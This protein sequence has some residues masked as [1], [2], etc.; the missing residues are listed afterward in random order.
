MKNIDITNAAMRMP[1]DSAKP[2]ET[3]SELP[4]SISDANVPARITPAA[5]MVGPPCLTASAAA[6]RGDLPSRASSR[7]R[8]IIRML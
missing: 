8:A 2:I 5:A 6:S 4:P 7:S 3:I 1:N